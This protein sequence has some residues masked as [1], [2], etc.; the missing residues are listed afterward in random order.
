MT[1]TEPTTG[2]RLIIAEAVCKHCV[3]PIYLPDE[4]CFATLDDDRRCDGPG[5]WGWHDPNQDDWQARP[6]PRGP[7]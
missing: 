3:R 4:G 1:V 7:Q 5:S 6:A 2:Q